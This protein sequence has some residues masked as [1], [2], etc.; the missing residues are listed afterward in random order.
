VLEPDEATNEITVVSIH[1]GVT[2]EQ[3]SGATGWPVKFATQVAETPPPSTEELA[4][5]RELH[6][7]TR[8]AIEAV[9]S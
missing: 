1:S 4:V 6:A 9:R 7:R 3:I 5:L 8:A 2:R